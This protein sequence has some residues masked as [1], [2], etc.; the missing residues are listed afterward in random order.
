MRSRAI[1]PLALAVALAAAGGA[2]AQSRD[3]LVLANVN[4][5]EITRRQLVT[6]LLD[7]RG[8]EALEKMINRTIL[9]QEAAKLKITVTEAEVEQKLGDIR[10]RFKS[11]GDYKMFLERSQVQE[12][13]LKENL[14]NTLLIQKVALHG[15]PIQDE[16]LDQYDVRI[17]N[18]KDKAAA[19]KLVQ[20]LDGGKINF[21]RLASERSLDPQL[22][23]AGG[24][25][26][27]FL[28]VEMLDVWQ[29]IQDQKLKPGGYT[30]TPVELG[31]LGWAVIKYE[32]LI[33]A[34]NAS[35]SE[36]DR[37]VAAMTVYR[38]DQWLN[39]ARGKAKV[40]KKPLSQPVVAVVNG[41][42]I[43]RKALIERLLAYN[44]RE[45]LDQLANRTMLLQAA[46]KAST[47][48][49]D[50]EAEQ[51]YQDAR[52]AIGDEQKYRQYLASSNL[53]EQQF[54]D[55]LRY[56]L[57]MEKVALKESPITEDDLTRYDMRILTAPSQ[58]VAMEWIAE[59]D[60]GADFAKMVTERSLDPDSRKS[61]G[62]T[63]PFLKIEMLDVWRAVDSQKVKPGGF[64]H[65][66]VLLTDSSWVVLKLEGVIP[67]TGIPKEERENLVRQVT[68]Y[69][70]DQWL[71]QARSRAKIAYPVELNLVVKEG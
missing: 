35:A 25:V 63:R 7:Y 4:G 51:R 30:K 41:E 33:P 6:R 44:G 69:R 3:D 71:S 10:K 62:R 20:D 12:P 60:K 16:E 46:K 9:N 14:Q 8:D 27:P 52:K 32:A 13:Q 59:L 66:P 17:I 68:R 19:E 23:A 45:A 65:M 64:T 11:D 54:K 40:E 50:A 1:L 48:V 21:A 47:T 67:P 61:G 28:K 26:K 15:S 24:R 49:S 57:L 5:E 34:L 36:R 43:Q 70:V 56:T 22:K 37:L 38:V 31:T 58:K 18:V 29:A 42:N 39:Q 2:R 53:S 55:E